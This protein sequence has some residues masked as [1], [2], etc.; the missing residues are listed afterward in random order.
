MERGKSGIKGMGC[1]IREER[2]FERRQRGSD[3]RRNERRRNEG[4]DIRRRNGEIG[5]GEKNL[6]NKGDEN[7]R[8]GGL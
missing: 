7:E 1:D 8:N 3:G 6:R 4:K 2:K 5:L